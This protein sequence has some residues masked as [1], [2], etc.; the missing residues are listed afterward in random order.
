MGGIQL[1][2]DVD[3]VRKAASVASQ[4]SG[5]TLDSSGLSGGTTA[6][7]I[8]PNGTAVAGTAF[9][10]TNGEVVLTQRAAGSPCIVARINGTN[11]FAALTAV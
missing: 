5:D 7:F 6:R 1:G 3:L 8:L 2:A 11:F 10:A 4:G 9:P